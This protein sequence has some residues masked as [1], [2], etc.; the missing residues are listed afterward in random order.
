[1]LESVTV[2]WIELIPRVIW[3]VVA[4]VGLVSFQGPISSAIN[5]AANGGATIEFAGLKMTLVKS[6]VP[7]P[8]E[9]IKDILPKINGDM[10]EFI[11]ANV[12]GSNTPDVCY[13]DPGLREFQ[14][15]S[16]TQNLVKLGLI[17]VEKEQLN[18]P[19]RQG[20]PCLAGGKTRFTELYDTV[21]I[22]LTDVL[23]AVVFSH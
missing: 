7:P 22:Y 4:V 23:K 20:K 2:A 19:Q 11:V 12:G 15:G 21:R 16:V 3:P 9:R 6:A 13:E 5:N 8:P 14:E 17:T 18:D 10:I 1:M